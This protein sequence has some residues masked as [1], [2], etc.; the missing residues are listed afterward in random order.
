MDAPVPPK[1]L[2]VTLGDDDAAVPLPGKIR[3]WLFVVYGNDRAR[4]IKLGETAIT[5][6]RGPGVDVVLNDDRASKVHCSARVTAGDAV[7]IVDQ[8]SRNGTF[9]DGERIGRATLHP[10]SQVRIGHT[11]LRVE[12]KEAEQVR[13]EEELFQAAVTDVLTGIPNRRW[14]EDRSAAAGA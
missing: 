9:V 10:N 12:L 1:R 5:L 7:E 8:G 14:F 13:L 4:H 3:P 2:D 6:G 11:I